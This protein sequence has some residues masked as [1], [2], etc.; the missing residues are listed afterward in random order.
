VHSHSYVVS[1]RVC[2]RDVWG[3]NLDLEADYI[4][5]AVHPNLK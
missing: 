3:L 2:I 5:W 4:A 1:N